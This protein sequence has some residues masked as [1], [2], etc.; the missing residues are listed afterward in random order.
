MID[1]IE[2]DEEE[3]IE[4]ETIMEAVV[5]DIV[6]GAHLPHITEDVATIAPVAIHP[7]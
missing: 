1:T 7:G 2:T 3:G 4:T 6:T 5:L